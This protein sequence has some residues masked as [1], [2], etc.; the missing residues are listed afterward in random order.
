M[1]LKFQQNLTI[2]EPILKLASGKRNN[3]RLSFCCRARS[4]AA[5]V[6]VCADGKSASSGHLTQIRFD[7]QV[8]RT[9][10]EKRKSGPNK[11]KGIKR[12]IFSIG[13]SIS[14]EYRATAFLVLAD[15]PA[16]WFDFH[17]MSIEIIAYQ[18]LS[19]RVAWK[20]SHQLNCKSNQI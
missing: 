20:K 9:N 17:W 10:Q 7:F 19:R 8:G 5:V 13:D 6:C 15:L 16:L 18:H 2:L 4:S 11:W 3:P 14:L 12:I 1:N